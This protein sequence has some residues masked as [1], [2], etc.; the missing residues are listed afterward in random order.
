MDAAV[1][2]AG[3]RKRPYER[4]ERCWRVSDIDIFWRVL[5]W[6]KTYRLALMSELLFLTLL[7]SLTACNKSDKSSAQ[8]FPTADDAGNALLQ[9]A[10]SGDQNAI[11]AVLGPESK[12]LISSGDPT[13]G[14]VRSRRIHRGLRRDAPLPQDA[15]W[16]PNPAGRS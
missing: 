10:K 14:Q 6:L 12:E 5:M 9:A 11:L 13:P 15:R 1:A 16:W 4:V 2:A 3:D 7:F 8:V